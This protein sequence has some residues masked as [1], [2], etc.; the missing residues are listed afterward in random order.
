[1]SLIPAPFLFRFTFPVARV[2]KLPRGKAPMLSLPASCRLP[3]PSS[4]DGKEPFA[5]MSLAWNPQGLAIEISVEGKS[6]L[7]YCNPEAIG[8]SDTVFVWIDTRDTQTQHRASRF[9][10]HFIAMPTGEGDDG[11]TPVF[12][13]LP[14]ARAR[15]EAPDAE[16]E[17]LLAESDTSKTG[18]RL[19]MWFP[20]ESLHGFE[21]GPG[22]RL[23]FYI[24]IQDTELGRQ[25]LTV[26]EDFPYD[27]D[28]SQWV[29][30]ELT[31]E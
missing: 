15:E 3:F 22:A 23:G 25:T 1:M 13:Q 21:P 9:C 14:V 27:M 8:T 17:S 26:S 19:A 7:P 31:S 6:N 5:A 29:S 11:M 24:A 16:P 12:R 4:L 18:Y 20:K 10:H 28:P 30:L 2:D